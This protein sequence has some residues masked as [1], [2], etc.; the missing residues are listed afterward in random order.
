MEGTITQVI[1]IDLAFYVCVVWN[2]C[3]MKDSS[4][5]AKINFVVVTYFLTSFL[6]YKGG[7][8]SSSSFA[9]NIFGNTCSRTIMSRAMHE[10]K[11]TASRWLLFNTQMSPSIND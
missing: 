1:V 7:S 10:G 5:Q 2:M 4:M 6:P 3:Q 8:S 9:L 11:S